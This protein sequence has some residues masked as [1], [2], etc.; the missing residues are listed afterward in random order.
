MGLF[1][2]KHKEINA[3]P[4]FDTTHVQQEQQ[5]TMQ[6]LNRQTEA[7]VF[8][9]PRQAA[10]AEQET[11]QRS[12]GAFGKGRATEIQSPGKLES[13]TKDDVST[14]MQSS[15]EQDMEE[16]AEDLTSIAILKQIKAYN[17]PALDK[18]ARP[19]FF[20]GLKASLD[21]V[22]I[23]HTTQLSERGVQLLE[24]YHRHFN[25]LA[26]GRLEVPTTQSTLQTPYYLV[27]GVKNPP[28]EKDFGK[29]KTVLKD[30]S[31]VP[32]FDH[33]PHVSDV[34]QGYIGDCF[35]L[36]AVS[37]MVSKDPQMIKDMMRD[38]GDGTVTVK[39]NKR[40]HVC[41]F[42]REMY[43]KDKKYEELSAVERV[44]FAF[45]KLSTTQITDGF[46]KNMAV[47]ISGVSAEAAI[48]MCEKLCTNSAWDNT[49]F[50]SENDEAPENALLKQLNR[51]A[52]LQVAEKLALSD[53]VN[54][55]YNDYSNELIAQNK[56]GDMAWIDVA[57]YVTIKKEVT[58]FKESGKSAYAQGALWTQLLERAYAASEQSASGN[59]LTA[60]RKTGFQALDDGGK[61]GEALEILCG[62][63]RTELINRGGYDDETTSSIYSLS[64]T[65][66]KEL[67][68]KDEDLAAKLREKLPALANTPDSEILKLVQII[69]KADEQNL[70][71][72]NKITFRSQAATLDEIL[73]LI[74]E[75]RLALIEGKS[76]S[77]EENVQQRALL[78][79]QLMDIMKN[80]ASSPLSFK[81]F[82]GQYSKSA[83]DTYEKI[84][85][86]LNEG[87]LVSASTA[88]FVPKKVTEAPG[89]NNESMKEG[90]AETHA[91]TVLGTK[92]EQG[93]RYISLRNPWGSTIRS[94]YKTE[95][96]KIIAMEN[97]TA[98]S[99]GVFFVEL[100]D[101]VANYYRVDAN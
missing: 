34:K 47:I 22:Y 89:L 96:G 86:S 23:S 39:L 48:R 5:D 33:E 91:Y 72:V 60:V 25:G 24:K 17:D 3:A 62:R 68:A 77:A 21:T 64:G 50:D 11:R 53:A 20:R 98:D 95:E 92:E 90:L 1:G 101:F 54:E 9:Q 80:S 65:L 28:L 13:I 100:N 29:N 4:V 85:T 10:P 44:A 82:S 58:V 14:S 8:K 66:K 31:D 2:E 37:G 27:D 69:N 41:D 43:W 35:F 76:A 32:L 99:G 61:A 12:Y 45:T 93:I 46:M 18:D 6:L 51:L 81:P 56:P 7:N 15:V 19:E 87:K 16:L 97:Q 49:E 57:E 52:A 75:S 83:E 40:M 74:T 30:M 55:T 94:Y 42:Q 79:Q 67:D 84:N 71:T 70:R 59:K 26:V 73:P 36:A 88:G 63:K 78:A 38:N